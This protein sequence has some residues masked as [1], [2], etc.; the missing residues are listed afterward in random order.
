MGWTQK[1]IENAF[2]AVRKKAVTDKSYRQKVLSDPKAAIKALTGK[3]VPA[4]IQIKVIENDP[5]Y[6]MTFVLP[7]MISEE[8]SEKDLE[9]VAGGGCFIDFGGCG[10]EACAAKASAEA[11]VR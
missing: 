7:E 9:K 1:E 4:G 11:S 6:A 5:K 3:D 2:V 10:A 8:I